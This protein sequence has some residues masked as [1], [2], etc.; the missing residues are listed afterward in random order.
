MPVG[1]RPVIDV[2]VSVVTHIE[3]WLIAAGDL[4][5]LEAQV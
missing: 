3:R 5:P 4:D 2:Y 1:R